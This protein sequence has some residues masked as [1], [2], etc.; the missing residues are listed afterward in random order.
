MAQD[1]VT[2]IIS[3][4]LQGVN[5]TGPVFSLANVM[6]IFL[7]NGYTLKD[8]VQR[9]TI[10]PAKAIRLDGKLGSLTPGYPAR[11]TVFELQEGS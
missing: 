5:I 2:D 8:V 4:D 9:V 7:N 3:S 6:S 11:I 1:V 10:N